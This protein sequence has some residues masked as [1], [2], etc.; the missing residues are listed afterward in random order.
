MDN[1]NKNVLHPVIRNFK[2]TETRQT[3]Q[4]HEKYH[5][6]S[7]ESFLSIIS[8]N[9]LRFTDARYMNDKTELIYFVKILIDFIGKSKEKF[10]LCLECINR[11]FAQYDWEKIKNFEIEHFDLTPN[12]Q[13]ISNQNI[14]PKR[15]YIFCT[16]TDSDSLS[17]WNYYVKGG[18]YQGYNIGFN[19]NKL[20]KQFEYIKINDAND[21]N[22]Y[23][24]NVIYD[25]KEQHKAIEI[26]LKSREHFMQ[27][28]I[29]IW[30]TNIE[31]D[32]FANRYLLIG[33]EL[34][35]QYIESRGAFY[36]HPCFA[37]EKEFRIV[38]EIN[39][40]LIPHSEKE[41]EVKFGFNGIFE[42]FCTKNGLVIPFLNVPI[43]NDAINNVTI[44]PMTEFKIAKQS[45]LELFDK[46]KIKVDNYTIRKS[47]IPIRF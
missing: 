38:V 10:P 8:G 2:E 18:N 5:Y 42:D 45:V 37:H 44:S 24:G 20:L 16:S 29:G 1:L 11:I 25:V 27:E 15:I 17:M 3:L 19:I 4:M 9:R 28:H 39:K 34:I 21:F 32:L 36:K 7:P 43:E 41:A 31:K 30:D 23:Y 40:N 13:D 26:F 47:Q 12:I 46:K 33:Q 14:S 6:T 22:I 35:R